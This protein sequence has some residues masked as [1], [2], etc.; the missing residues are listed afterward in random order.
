MTQEQ[1]IAGQSVALAVAALFAGKPDRLVWA[2]LDAE[3]VALGMALDE[4]RLRD[5]ERHVVRIEAL[6]AEVGRRARG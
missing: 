1:Q 4:F 5:I 6:T 2:A 3:N